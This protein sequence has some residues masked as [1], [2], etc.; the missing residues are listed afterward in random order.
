MFL[1][2]WSLLWFM[3]KRGNNV[4][5]LPRDNQQCNMQRMQ[6][7]LLLILWAHEDYYLDAW[8][9]AYLGRMSQP[10]RIREPMVNHKQLRSLKRFSRRSGFLLHGCGLYHSYGVNL[11]SI[12]PDTVWSNGIQARFFVMKNSVLKICPRF[13]HFMI[14]WY[15]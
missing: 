4:L 6:W 9:R 13:V 14:N 2:D 11:N 15:V 7:A 5:V 3:H 1:N 10:C 8:K 12:I